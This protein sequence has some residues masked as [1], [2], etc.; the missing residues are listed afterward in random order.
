MEIFVLQ[1]TNVVIECPLV[2]T[3]NMT[4]FYDKKFIALGILINPEF[5]QRF[6]ISG[7]VRVRKYN[8]QITNFTDG[9][10]GIYRCQ[11]IYGVKYKQHKV[12][13][14]IC[15]KLKYGTNVCK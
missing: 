5:G 11:G 6:K 2:L 10:Q 9:D 1:Y 13:V 15:G 14:K 12:N 4:W 3:E 8:L 7:Y